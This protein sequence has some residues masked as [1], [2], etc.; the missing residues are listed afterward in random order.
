[1]LWTAGFD[2]LYACQ[3]RDFDLAEGLH[4][5]PQRLSTRWKGLKEQSNELAGVGED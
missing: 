4:S 3:D 1:M 5:I 2:V